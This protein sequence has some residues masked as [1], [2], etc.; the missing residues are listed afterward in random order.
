LTKVKDPVCD[1]VIEQST[2][3]AHGTYA[4]EIVYFCSDP[5]QKTYERTHPRS[6]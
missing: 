2:A 5:C 4:G 3:A 1:M 6:A